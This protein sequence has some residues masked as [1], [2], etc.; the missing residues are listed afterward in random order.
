M[1]RQFIIVG[2]ACLALIAS[3]SAVY[4]TRHARDI[5]LRGYVDPTQTIDLPYRVPRLGVNADLQ[6][7]DGDELRRQF[8]RMQAMNVTWVR[9]IADWRA[10][11]AQVGVYDWSTWDRITRTIADYP[12]LRLVVVIMN[13]PAWARTSDSPTAPPTDPESIAAFLTAFAERYGDAVDVYQIW[14]EPNLAIAWG[15][16]DPRPAEYGAL[17]ATAYTAIKRVDGD[18]TVMTAALAPTTE[19]GGRNIADILYLQ[20]LYR[21]GIDAYFDAVAGKPYG[22]DTAPDDRRVRLDVLNFSRLIAL[23]EVMVEHGDSRKALWA[24][25]WGWNSLPPDWQGAPSIWGQVSASAQINHTLNALDRA[26]REWAWLGGMI[27]HHWQPDRPRDDPQWGFA[28]IGPDDTPT[29]LYEALAA[30]PA[31]TSASNG[32]Y[33]P[34]TPHAQY[35]GVWQFSPLGAD[36]GWLETSDS[37]LQFEFMGRDIALLLREG[38]YF[39][40]LYPT[41]DGEPANATPVDNRGNAYVVLRS[42]T[43]QETLTLTPISRDL[44]LD[45]HTL[46]VV[47]DRGWDRWAIAGYAVSDGNLA[48]PYQQ[49]IRWAWVTASIAGLAVIATGYRLPWLSIARKFRF[50]HHYLNPIW[51]FV[52]SI[53][54][55]L[56]LTVGMLLTFGTAE[57]NIFRRDIWIAG[58]TISVSG[59]WLLITHLMPYTLP[60][61][62]TIAMAGVL[63]VLIYNRLQIGL[64]LVIVYAPFF[65]FPVEL[66]LFAF[67][68]AE[69]I[70]LITFGA[71]ILDRLV[72][73][74]RWRQTAS[75]QYPL[76][77]SF[78]LHPLDY[79]VIAWGIAGVASLLWTQRLDPA[80]TELRTL[81]I[82]PILFYV[83]LRAIH[84]TRRDT[85]SAPPMA[86]YGIGLILAGVLVALIGLF[87]FVQGQAII[88]AEAGTRRLASVYGSPNNVGLLL[89]RCVPFALAWLLLRH[90]RIERW[91]AGGALVIMLIAVVLT[92]SLGALLFGIPAG[93]GAVVL[94]KWRGRA[95]FPLLAVAIAGVIAVAGLTQVS[96]RFASLLDFSSGTTFI[97]LRVWESTLE[98]LA[99]HP[100]TGLGLDQFLYDYSA[101]YI[102]PDAIVDPD[103]NHP[104]NIILDYWVRLG[105]AGVGIII[106]TQIIFWRRAIQQWRQQPSNALLVG[107]MGAM[108]A[109][110]A[111]GLIDNSVY[112]N[113]LALIFVLLLAIVAHHDTS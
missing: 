28:L 59:S 86:L 21:L 84:R 39:A 73:W 110:L 26:E 62:L 23:R 38:D 74:G 2:A 68:M 70:L 107:A 97:R 94:L 61:L 77:W 19:R 10:I 34:L 29:A 108:A 53:I 5:Q 16:R 37:R 102:R 31:S 81:V 89:G 63:F 47:P 54:T 52:V 42:E 91:L 40:F 92:Q 55:S 69:L 24:S 101:A 1:I 49:Q 75:S 18:A 64:W 6:Q 100:V 22:F 78:A 106:A 15:E 93:I 56:A 113:D 20:A 4:A 13:S 103:L 105:G 11:E 33:H 82:E 8:D 41:I 14:D 72:A 79:V 109:L 99:D 25:H 65:L 76:R 57:A 48:E 111:H 9:Q 67:P 12:D 17:L 32:L 98:I 71:W 36:I 66:Y 88:T 30:R 87:L 50:V 85:P 90:T 35:H 95:L 44:S 83:M 46:T 112:V 60:F 51:Q 3:L 45:T 43:Q 104:H 96:A 7:Y 58:G 27:L 80:L